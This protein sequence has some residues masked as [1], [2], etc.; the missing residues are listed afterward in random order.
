VSRPNI[1]AEWTRDRFDGQ[2][3]ILG[4][5]VRALAES[6]VRAGWAVHAADLFCDLDLQAIATT[7]VPAAHGPAEAG[8]GYPSSLL[9]AAEDFPPSIPWCYT[10][11]VENHPDIIDAI[12]RVRPLAGNPGDIVRQLRDPLH[13]SAA[14][15]AAGLSFPET[16][17]SSNG[18]PLD[19]TFLVK[20]L[21]SA[22]GRG[23]R[24]WTRAV[25]ADH[26][27]NRANAPDQKQIWQRFMPGTPLSASFCF[28]EGSARLLGV[29]QQLIGEP[30]CHA[31][32]FAWCG[33][34]ALRTGS[35]RT[36]TDSLAAPLE[37]L[38]GILAERFQPVGLVGV[39]LVVDADGSVEVI[40]VN[41]RPTAS[42]ELFERSGAGSI[43]GHHLAACGYATPSRSRP[44]QLQP[45]P[46][47]TW[48]KAVLFAARATPVSQTL[49]DAL[50][51]ET[52]PWTHADGGW[53][54]LADIPRPG[55]TIAS[56]APVVTL[57]A[58]ARAGDDA[59]AILRDRVARID[60]LLDMPG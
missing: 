27:A 23:I 26:T 36:E 18:V 28:A 7:A 56:G 43:A 1:A 38:G 44:E 22:G 54:A 50:V 11:A 40:E 20:P 24:R 45:Q 59:L 16:L 31:G 58:T 53:P 12:A 49:I 48:A 25:A 21:A 60:T 10:G 8:T 47:S 17:T 9:A 5:S 51:Q 52:H 19:G 2:L 3:V 37:R 55:Q 15:N 42:M 32:P 34:V 33:A 46:A 41:P 57:F 39:D 6:A 14:A 35:S 4:A 13:V 30:W 29:S